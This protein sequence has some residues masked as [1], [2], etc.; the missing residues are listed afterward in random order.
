MKSNDDESVT[1]K[2]DLNENH[3]L[4]TLNDEFEHSQKTSEKKSPKDEE[5]SR[6]RSPSI[7]SKNYKTIPFT[8]NSYESLFSHFDPRSFNSRD[9]S[10]DF[11]ESCKQKLLKEKM[12]Q[13]ILMKLLVPTTIFN[14]EIN[15]TISKR[16]S[17]F[18][19]LNA[20]ISYNKMWWNRFTS[21]LW[22]IVGVFMIAAI[23]ILQIV[24]ETYVKEP[25]HSILQLCLS[26]F[27][28]PSW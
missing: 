6:H 28:A 2:K 15:E 14:E 23:T 13:Q 25:Y 17:E 27:T 11:I 5:T 3:E 7:L 18:F 22:I 10:E 26:V 4:E 8:L 20:S 24:F 19:A 21:A 1:L 16:L 9:I 12:N